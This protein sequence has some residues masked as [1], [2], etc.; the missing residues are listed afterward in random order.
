[1]CFG[2][3]HCM[4]VILFIYKSLTT[5]QLVKMSFLLTYCILITEDSEFI[6]PTKCGLVT[7]VTSNK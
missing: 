4:G 7:K 1:M 5:G 6:L 3:I 2:R